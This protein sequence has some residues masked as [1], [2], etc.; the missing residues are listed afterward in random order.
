M[1]RTEFNED[2]CKGCGLC[3]EACPRQILSFDEKRLN[4]KGYRL[5]VCSDVDKCTGCAICARICPDVVIEV[6]RE[7]VGSSAA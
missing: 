6:Y 7:V 4:S 5:V 1:G 3:V 2:R